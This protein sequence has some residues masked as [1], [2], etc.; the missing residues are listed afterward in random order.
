MFFNKKKCPNCGASNQKDATRCVRCGVP[1][2][3][4]PIKHPEAF[5]DL[6][7]AIRLNP[8]NAEAYYQRGLAYQKE[9]YADRAIQDFDMAIR[10]DPALAKAY[11]NR[12]YAYLNQKQY[13][14]AI[15]DCTEAIKLNP[16]DAVARYNRGVTYK[17]VDKKYDAKDDFE[18][19]IALAKDPRLIQITKQQLKEV[20]K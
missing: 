19:V 13:D 4:E 15:A 2:P 7:E 3:P 20:S 14:R 9:G 8:Q 5:K 11:S 10:L 12:G 17:L 18:K 6:D 16:D 1:F